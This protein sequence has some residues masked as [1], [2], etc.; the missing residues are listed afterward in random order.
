[1]A[2]EENRKESPEP[3]D[4]PLEEVTL[5]FLDDENFLDRLLGEG[6]EK[7]LF[8]RPISDVELDY[9][10]KR[11]AFLIIQ[12][13]DVDEIALENASVLKGKSGWDIHDNGQVLRASPGRL[14][15]GSSTNEDDEGEGGGAALYGTIIGQCIHTAQEMI[16]IAAQRWGSVEIVEGYRTMQLAAAVHAKEKGLTVFGFEPG[17]DEEKAFRRVLEMHGYRPGAETQERMPR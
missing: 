3:T 14:A 6:I 5:D 1:M 8:E 12:D 11:Y 2:E 9:L 16:D 7:Q 13:A 17:V 4:S 10:L 15:W